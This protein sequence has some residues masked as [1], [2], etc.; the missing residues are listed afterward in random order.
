M[1]SR[2]H[3]QT[4]I[5]IH[6][7]G[8]FDSDVSAYPAITVI[9]R[10]K[11]GKTVVASVTASLDLVDEDDLVAYLRTPSAEEQGESPSTALRSVVINRWFDG[12]DPWPCNS[13]KRHSTLRLLEERFCDSRGWETHEGW[14]WGGDRLRQCFHYAGCGGCGAIKTASSCH[15]RG[16]TDWAA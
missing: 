15:G 7:A 2:Y 3:V 9:R 8:A 12:S 10:E 14:D 16:Y 5:K 1:A 6:H 11:Q 4:I 13:P